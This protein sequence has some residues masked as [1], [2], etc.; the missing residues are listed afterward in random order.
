M[1][2]SRLGA[3][4][5]AALFLG[6]CETRTG[7]TGADSVGDLT[8]E[9]SGYVWTW[10]GQR[11]DASV[12]LYQRSSGELAGDFSV[13]PAFCIAGGEAS[14]AISGT[15]VS[16]TLREQYGSLSGNGT[17]YVDSAGRPQEIELEAAGYGR[18]AGRD[19]TVR[20]WRL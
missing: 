20:L 13:D 6:A 16:L 10:A 7:P 1:I 11:Y 3:A 12:Y 9:W 2:R 15:A 5:V 14:G 18:C 19:G 4:L 8:G 17:V